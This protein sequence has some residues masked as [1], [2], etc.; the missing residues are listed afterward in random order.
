MNHP[1]H[2]ENG[3]GDLGPSYIIEHYSLRRQRLHRMYPNRLECMNYAPV[4]IAMERVP[5]LV[6]CL[7][8]LDRASPSVCSNSMH[9]SP[10]SGVARRPLQRMESEG[11][12]TNCDASLALLIRQI[13]ILCVAWGVSFIVFLAMLL[14]SL[15]SLLALMLTGLTVVLLSQT[16]Y[17]YVTIFAQAQ[18]A[19]ILDRGIISY[20]PET[21][22]DYF[23]TTSIDECLRLF[24]GKQNSLLISMRR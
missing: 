17:Q 10:A 7:S 11:S 23:T 21:L 16:L 9:K 8:S 14:P 20:L 3:D 5:S 18:V 24:S 4:G 12:N 2:S 1:R 13:Q 6:S 15:L 19:V 22:R